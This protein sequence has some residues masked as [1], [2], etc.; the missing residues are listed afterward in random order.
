MQL[1]L[2]ALQSL[3]NANI[4]LQIKS[5]TQAVWNIPKSESLTIG[6]IAA[7][8]DWMNAT[9]QQLRSNVRQQLKSLN[10]RSV[11][12][13]LAHKPQLLVK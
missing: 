12:G 1:Q 7:K 4:N 8:G 5:S 6:F 10:Q 9:T 11:L 2:P 13:L 3:V